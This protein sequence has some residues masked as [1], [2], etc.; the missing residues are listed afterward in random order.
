MPI[1]S[2]IG[3]VSEGC[4]KHLAK[5][6]NCVKGENGHAIKNSQFC[7]KDP[8]PGSP[9]PQAENLFLLVFHPSLLASLLTLP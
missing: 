3:S 2:G 4:A 5:I 8:A 6:L 1:V 7:E 9:P